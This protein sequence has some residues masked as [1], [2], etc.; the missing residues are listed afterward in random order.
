MVRLFA[1]GFVVVLWLASCVA[2]PHPVLTLEA[3][4]THGAYLASN[5][6]HA[7][8]EYWRTEAERRYPEGCFLI[9]AHGLGVE[10]QWYAVSKEGDF[11][12]AMPAL[13]ARLR[14]TTI[15][16]GLRVVIVACNPDRLACD[17]PGV[18]YALGNVWLVPDLQTD[19]Q[20]ARDLIVNDVVDIFEFVEN[21]W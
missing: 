16:S 6:L 5:D 17:V 19:V 15:P 9:V 12:E 10:N 14:A 11:I 7:G 2:Y 8:V 1:A 18:S 4:E 21:P 13:I 20:P 3:D